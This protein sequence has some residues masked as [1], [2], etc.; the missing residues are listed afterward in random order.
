MYN[1]YKKIIVHGKLRH[2]DDPMGL[3]GP[4]DFTSYLQCNSGDASTTTARS[5]LI[6][7]CKPVTLYRLARGSN[8]FSQRLPRILRHLTVF[9]ESAVVSVPCRME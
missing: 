7:A 3:A 2:N 6:S 4:R 1:R 9:P 8:T 5:I